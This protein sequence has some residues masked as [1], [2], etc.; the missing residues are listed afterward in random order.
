[1]S[2]GVGC[3]RGLDPMLLWLQ[4]RPK[5]TAPVCP[6]AWEPP[7]AMGVAPQ[8]KQ[9]KKDSGAVVDWEVVPGGPSGGMRR[10]VVCGEGRKPLQ[11]C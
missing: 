11:V 10:E 5:V 9:K 7:Y 1:M 3:R 6:L 8:K 4:H 2:Y